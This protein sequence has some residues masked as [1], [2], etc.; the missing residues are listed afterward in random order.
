MCCSG[1][2]RILTAA[3]VFMSSPCRVARLGKVALGLYVLFLQAG[4]RG[5][6]EGWLRASDVLQA[7]AA[8]FLA[9]VSAS[10]GECRVRLVQL[11]PRRGY[12]RLSR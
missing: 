10:T 8:G 4:V 7:H 11:V 5:E 1:V 6:G 12:E 2:L 3:G 9:L